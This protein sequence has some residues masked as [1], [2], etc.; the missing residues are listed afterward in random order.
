MFDKS[1]L[2]ILIFIGSAFAIEPVCAQGFGSYGPSCQA[3]SAADIYCIQHGGCSSGGNC[4]FP[5][6]SY[7]ELWSFFNGT[8]PGRAYYE[9][10]IWEREVY[11]FLHGDEGY[12]APYYT[13]GM[14]P[15]Y[16]TSPPYYV[17]SP[18]YTTP[19]YN[20]NY[21]SPRSGLY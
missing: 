18:Y 12:Y 8:C 2:L 13:P 10:M 21:N 1:A 7:C 15:P 6:G 11:N 5:D 14:Y 19:Y 17:N 20:T 16:S 3:R 9:Q 4:Y